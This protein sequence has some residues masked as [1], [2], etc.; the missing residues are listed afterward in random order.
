M[1][2]RK[3]KINQ[4]TQ[5][6]RQAAALLEGLRK[7]QLAFLLQK[8]EEAELRLAELG[9]ST[10]RPTEMD[11]PN[12]GEEG[13]SDFSDMDTMDTG[14]NNPNDADDSNVSFES[15]WE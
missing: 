15:F 6:M 8:R 2:S 5:A 1:F 10:E 3:P 12:V 9:G 4:S 14:G 13:E 7:Q 11:M